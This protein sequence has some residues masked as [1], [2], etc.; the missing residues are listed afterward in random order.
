MEDRERGGKLSPEIYVYATNKHFFN[1]YDA[2]RIEKVKIEI[3][4]Y[5][6]ATNR[7]TGH[8]NAWLDA[9]DARLLS[10]LVCH[11][12]F[13]PVTGGKWERF[14]GSQR[15]DGSIESRTVT[16][17]WDE[18]DG[19]RFAA[20]PYRISIANGPGRKTKTGGVSP[21]GEATSRMSMRMPETD[22]IK[23]MLA[24]GGYIHAY[25]TAH[26]HRLVAQRLHDLRDKLAERSNNRPPQ[27][28][29]AGRQP[30]YAGSKS[31]PSP[32]VREPATIAPARPVLKAIQ[33]GNSEGTRRPKTETARAG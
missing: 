14:G 31:E 18:G 9:D 17:E 12:L 1:V 4:G 28:L 19:G 6:P 21:T 24:L 33:G 3:A 26:H 16:I 30:A 2:L 29:D 7:Q 32:W 15:E 25:E 27:E 20:F 8:A 11:R 5:D 22:M 23:L 13:A 10:H